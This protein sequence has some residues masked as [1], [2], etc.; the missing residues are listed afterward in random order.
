MGF[1]LIQGHAMPAPDPEP[2]KPR[3]F[4]DSARGL[5]AFPWGFL[6]AIGLIVVV[7]LTMGTW[8][9]RSG[10]SSQLALSWSSSCRAAG[11]PE[12]R[13]EVVCFG[14]SLAKL[15]IVPRVLEHELGL[16]AYNL[17]VLAGQAPGSF[18]LLKR[19][20]E[21]GH[22][23]RAILV[24]FACPLLSV[25]PGRN[26]DCWAEIADGGDCLDLV[27]RGGEPWLAAEITARTILPSWRVRAGFR[28][29]LG[30]EPVRVPG[31]EGAILTRN[32]LVNQGAQV[33][34]KAFLP[35]AGALPEPYTGGSWAWRP[36]PTNERYVDAFLGLAESRGIPVFW[37]IPPSRRERI[38]RLGPAGVAAAHARFVAQRLARFPG[39]T[40]LDG[41]RLRWDDWGFRDPTHLNRD[42]AIAFS[43]AVARA[44]QALIPN[45][46]GPRSVDLAQ[47][48]ARRTPGLESLVEDLD[49]SRAI[50]ADGGP[51][52]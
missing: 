42:G 45:H 15:A 20:L 13:A 3:G 22:R 47:T 16:S 9:N 32:W 37:L 7:E 50:L 33:A 34:P 29:R 27:V 11:E 23:P 31:P 19:L 39:L 52:D 43:L 21:S 12:A 5:G 38:E 44:I 35:V 17:S 48:Q 24:D 8:A 18:M 36:D 4:H 2:R 40:V 6:G 14:D 46:H 28:T 10:P 49:Q 25:P 26:L 1:P 41:Q 51:R 30:L